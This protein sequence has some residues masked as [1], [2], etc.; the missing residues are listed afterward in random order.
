MKVLHAISSLNISSGGP[1]LSTWSL[2]RGLVYSGIR[3]DI[4][5]FKS[6]NPADKMISESSF[7]QVLSS[8]KIPRFAYSSELVPFLNCNHYDIY[9][10]HGL[11]E[12]PTHAIA[13]YARKARKPYLISPR[14][15]LYPEALNKSALFKKLAM[16]LYQRK[17]LERATVIHATCYQEMIYI[18]DMGF[19]NPIAIIPNSIDI[20]NPIELLPILKTKKQVGFVGRFAKIK[21]LE[22]LLQA[23]ADSGA[24]QGDWELVLIGDGDS[25][26]KNGL[27]QLAKSLG[28]ENLRLTGFLSGKEKE[29]A[30][31]N[32]DYLV[33]PSKSENFGM[34]VAEALLREIPVIASKGTPWEDLQIHQAG[35]W[36]N[37][38]RDALAH[39]LEKAMG[40]S[41]EARQLMGANGKKLVEKKYSIEGVAE[42]MIALYQWI[43]KKGDKPDFV[44]E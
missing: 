8:S 3:A 38:D 20:S 29:K 21:N 33:L 27:I 26:Y 31:K 25:D 4:V 16:L 23:W 10:G 6:K 42:Q 39:A 41:E 19:Q 13:N 44:Y 14:G 22:M 28:I 32:L 40:L 15:M 2:V 34:V 5:T 9:H 17:D 7:I 37:T 18:R 43:L 30:L 11:W 35:W 36:V 24:K 1:S 12:Y